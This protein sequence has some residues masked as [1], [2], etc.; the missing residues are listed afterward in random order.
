MLMCIIKTSIFASIIFVVYFIFYSFE[1][2]AVYSEFPYPWNLKYPNIQVWCFKIICVFAYESWTFKSFHL[3]QII[4]VYVLFDSLVTKKIS[5]K[6]HFI[7]IQKYVD[8]LH[9]IS[10]NNS[11]I[12]ELR[13]ITKW[14]MPP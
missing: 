11:T 4:N 9:F 13:P 14:T 3:V 5:N 1:F 7:L 6:Q 10:S 2:L 8:A 12:L